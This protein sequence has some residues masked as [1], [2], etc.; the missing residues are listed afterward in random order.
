MGHL[1]LVRMADADDR[2]LDLVGGIFADAQPRLRGHQHGDATGL[3]ELQRTG[4]VLVHESLFH[5]RA[6]R[7]IGRQHAGQLRMKRQQPQ[8]QCL[9]VRCADAV[10]HMR[11]AATGDVDH[12]PAHVAQARIDSDH[13][14]HSTH[15]C[16]IHHGVLFFCCTSTKGEHPPRNSA[17]VQT[18]HPRRRF[19]DTVPET[20]IPKTENDTFVTPI[21]PLITFG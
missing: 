14:Y 10:C 11:D 21:Y 6:L 1:P 7:P 4:P 12:A 20:A 15:P 5:R 9:P 3:P 2:F 19:E 8:R 13:T 18:R 17:L 16:P